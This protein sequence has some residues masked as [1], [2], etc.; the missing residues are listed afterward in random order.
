MSV[1]VD[2]GVERESPRAGTPPLAGR[3]HPA[4]WVAG[5][6]ALAV[7]GAAVASLAQNRAMSWPVVA[8]YVLSGQ[9]LSGLWLTIW[10]TAVVTAL[11]FLGGILV[12]AMRLSAN[13]VLQWIGWAYVWFFRSVPVLVQLLFWFNIG[14]L[15][16]SLSSAISAMTAAVLGLTLHEAALAGEIV[17]GGIL[18]VD[19]GQLEAGT[20]LGLSKIRIFRRVVLPQAMRSIVPAA[21]N[22]LIGTLKGTSMVSVIAVSDLLYSAQFIYNRTYEIVPLLAVATL[23]YLIVT[24]VLSVA[25][26]YIERY[27][28][29]GARRALPPTPWQRLRALVRRHP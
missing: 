11:G 7:V 10:L 5:A 24:S 14:Y 19:P 28:A 21:G 6:V 20:A 9:I 26:Y 22:L 1:S 8:S 12:A 2:P 23:W 29:R 13:P 15:Y 4:R 27:F 25:Q 16:P 17:R 3:R 18:A